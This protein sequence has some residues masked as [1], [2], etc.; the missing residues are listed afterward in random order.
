MMVSVALAYIDLATYYR[1]LDPLVRL[2]ETRVF[3]EI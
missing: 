1:R 3:E 2:A